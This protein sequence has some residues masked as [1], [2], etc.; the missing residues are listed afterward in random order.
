MGDGKGNGDVIQDH[1][2]LTGKDDTRSGKLAELHHLSEEDQV[3]EKKLLRKIDFLV[4]PLIV[5][6]Y[7]MNFIDRNNYAAARLQGLEDHLNLTS[8]RYQAGLGIFFVGYILGSIPSNQILNYTGR[9][10][11]Y[12]GLS[13]CAW[14]LVSALTALV[15][16]YGGILGCRLALGFVEA[17][18]FPGVLFYLSK[19][20]TKTELSMRMSIFYIGSLIAGALGSLI[21]AGILH[22]LAGKNGLPGWR[23]LYI[24]EGV[25]TV[26]L[27]LLV[28]FMLPEFPHTWKSLSPELRRIANR[29]MAIEA[30]EADIDEEKGMSQV[31]GFMLAM[32]DIRVHVLAFAFMCKSAAGGFSFFFPTLTSTLGYN[33]T[34]SLLLCAPPYVFVALWSV[35]HSWASDRLR[36]RFWFLM[37]PMP[38]VIV[39]W[40]IFMTTD[41]FGPRY[42]SLFLMLMI[43][44]IN[45]TF[46]AWIATSIP[47]PPAKR[48]AAYAYINAIGGS[49]SIWTPFTYRD[50][51]KPHYRPALG[52]N[53]GLWLVTAACFVFM[54]FSLTRENKRL[55]RL[56]DED[57][58]LSA[59]DF[60]KLQQTA[61][62]E[63][64][65]IATARRLQKNHRFVI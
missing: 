27:G 13:T 1:E 37:Y 8:E 3:L 44:S 7:L 52:L 42:L 47:R 56:E 49:A 20:Y 60:A 51:D 61:E 26:V 19:W 54:F 57:V 29:R 65:D 11:L 53:I 16:S 30:A 39:G 28:V 43:F 48:A 15:Q 4:M 2:I 46:F 25:I 58:P 32:K 33:N 18:F 55:D 14:G 12:L 5:V 35:A 6:I 23:W 21:A 62:V 59:E 38:V 22:G 63:G 45:G 41:S 9:P 34:I 24:I 50:E 17:P 40:I 31:K 10:S 64:V 36:K